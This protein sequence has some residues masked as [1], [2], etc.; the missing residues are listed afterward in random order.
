MKRALRIALVAVLA[1][2]S[3]A[4]AAGTVTVT[5]EAYSAVRKVKFAWTS[6]GAGAADG[7]TTGDFSGKI[8]ALVTVPNGGGTQPTDLYDL[9]V[10]DDD[11]TD[12][13]SGAGANR[14]NAST[15][16]VLSASLGIV[17]NDRL[18]LHVTNAGAA[19]GGTVYVYLR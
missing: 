7:A 5:E 6:D 9:T 1:L 2:T 18:T 19:K 3:E 17:A 13:L 14:S 10:V 12:V 15:Q 16:V 11:G 8:E 4:W